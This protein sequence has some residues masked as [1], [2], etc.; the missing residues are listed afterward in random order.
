MNFYPQNPMSESLLTEEEKKLAFDSTMSDKIKAIPRTHMIIN[1][2]KLL[3]WICE[4]HPELFDVVNKKIW[5]N[6][7]SPEWV[8]LMNM[9]FWTKNKEVHS[10]QKLSL[11]EQLIME[12]QRKVELF[13][14]SEQ[15]NETIRAGLKAMNKSKK[16]DSWL[17]YQLLT[18]WEQTEIML[19]ISPEWGLS[20]EDK[21]RIHM[22][23]RWGK[24]QLTLININMI[25]NKLWE[26]FRW[27]IEVMPLPIDAV[28]TH[29]INEMRSLNFKK[30]KIEI[31]YSENQK[32]KYIKTI[33]REDDISKLEQLKEATPYGTIWVVRE[34]WKPK[35]IKIEQ[36]L[37]PNYGDFM[38]RF[39]HLSD[40]KIDQDRN[41]IKIKKTNKQNETG[42]S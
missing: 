36:T 11:K 13:Q 41:I 34:M 10:Q 27:N 9:I 39:N 7:V 35:Y 37:K 6:I 15:K 30:K 26:E 40:F 22:L 18:K 38:K 17:I 19:Y 12:I 21:N 24:T 1:D 33:W 3:K 20:I 16:L 8:R 42:K 23:I 29:V 28:E 5:I 25:L 32:V 14:F 4:H 2:D 31:H